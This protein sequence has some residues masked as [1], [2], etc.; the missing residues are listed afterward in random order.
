[1]IGSI[2]LVYTLSDAP[3]LQRF[4]KN[5][6]SRY[7]GRISFSLYLV[8]G[9]ICHMI[10]HTIISKFWALTGGPTQALP[11]PGD[12]LD[13]SRPFE[14]GTNFGY[15][16]GVALTAVIVVPCTIWIADIFCRLVDEP[17]VN[18]ARTV[19]KFVTEE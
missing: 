10:G 16:S 8:H 1:M 17:F 18:L 4:F 3:V 6:F 7:L 11:V 5:S 14:G 12:L 13:P 15:E 2:L 19:E 9:P